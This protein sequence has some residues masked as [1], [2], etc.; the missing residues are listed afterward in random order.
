MVSGASFQ[1]YLE[2]DLPKS[3]F[4]LLESEEPFSVSKNEPSIQIKIKLVS[5]D[6]EELVPNAKAGEK[7]GPVEDPDLSTLYLVR[8]NASSNADLD[9]LEDVLL[10]LENMK[11]KKGE[12]KIKE[13]EDKEDIEDDC[14]NEFQEYVV[15][16][17]GT[18]KPLVSQC[19][20]DLTFTKEADDDVQLVVRGSRGIFVTGNYILT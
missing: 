8:Y 2:P 18:R 12:E 19:K 16:N 15:A 1:I 9:A 3:L 10:Y 7:D 17:L 4:D 20:M 14:V 13:D 5:V 11:E 6:P